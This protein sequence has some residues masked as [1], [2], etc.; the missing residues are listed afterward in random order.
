MKHKNYFYKIIVGIFSAMVLSTS[1]AQTNVFDDVIATSPDH[2][3]LEAA[4][5]QQGLDV[6]LQ[7]TQGVTVFAPT[8]E[9]FTNIAT[10]LGTD[11]NGLLALP[12]LT[13]ILTYHVLSSV[14]PSSAVTNG[15]IAQPLSTTNTVKMTVTSSGEVFVNQAQVTSIDLTADNGVVHVTN[16]VILPNET[17]V[18]VAIDNGFNALTSAVVF[19]EV[20]PA[21]TNP[22]SNYTVF[23]P[24]DQAFEDLASWLEVPLEDLFTPEFTNPSFLADVLYYHVL[25]SPVL[26][27]ELSNGAI[28][29]PLSSTNDLKVT[30][31]SS[32]DAFINQALITS[33]DIASDNG[34]VHVIDGVLVNFETVIDVAIDNG[35]TTLATAIVAAELMPALTDPYSEFTVFAPTNNAFDELA[36]ALNTDLSGILA[37]PNL[38]D[39]LL[40][41]VVDGYVT[42]GDLSNGPVST[43]NGTDVTVDLS[44]GVM[45]NN[46]NVT[47]P[48]IDADN[49]IVHVIDAVLLPTTSNLSE[50]ERVKIDVYPNPAR[51]KLYIASESQVDFYITDLHGNILKKGTTGPQPI[52]V[53]DL[54]NGAYLVRTSGQVFK[55]MKN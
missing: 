33:T 28:V 31:K 2:N 39:V 24:T 27:A 12:N 6:V 48:D 25:A 53:S 52:A 42:S 16:G 13:D 55:F 45:I 32:G 46:S 19:A 37:L 47:N 29:A 10:A 54:S 5:V 34:V 20:M 50:E 14:V 26:A 22:L 30:V 44:S 49:G 9:A 15:L 38:A 51:E 8:D 40:Y 21:L 35:F 41:H 4:L 3:Y 7:T 1:H 11:I 18:D 36:S 23:A 17:V 43:L